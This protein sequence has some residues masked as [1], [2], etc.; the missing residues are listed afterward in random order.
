METTFNFTYFYWATFICLLI[1]LFS[2]VY[3]KSVARA[4]EDTEEKANGRVAH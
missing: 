2:A 1:G 3:K 4:M